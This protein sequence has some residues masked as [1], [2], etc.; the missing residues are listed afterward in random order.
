ML[1]SG[2]FTTLGMMPTFGI[3]TTSVMRT[4]L[5]MLPTEE[6]YLVQHQFSSESV[7]SLR[8]DF[9]HM[10]NFGYVDNLAYVDDL[11][12]VDNLD[13]VDSFA[14]AGGQYLVPHQYSQEARETRVDFGC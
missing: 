1:P 11:A 4:T 14:R 8:V 7:L 9:W 6:T 13:Y 12:Y 2:V 10:D 3:V 5:G